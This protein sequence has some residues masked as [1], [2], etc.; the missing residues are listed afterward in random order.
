LARQ[1]WLNAAQPLWDARNIGLVAVYM[2]ASVVTDIFYIV[3]RQADIATAFAAVDQVMGA[4]G[5]L[6]VD[7]P[8]LQQARTLPGNDF[9]DNVLIACAMNA[10]VDMIVTRNLADFQLSSVPAIE[11]AQIGSYLPKP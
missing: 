7:A 3:R 8:L 9:E 4:F 6:D 1:P 2:P 11:P 10:Q 5:L